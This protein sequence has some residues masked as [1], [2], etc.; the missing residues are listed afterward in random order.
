MAIPAGYAWADGPEGEC[1]RCRRTLRYVAGE[2][3][4][5]GRNHWYLETCCTG[6]GFETL[7]CGRD[8]PES[9][10]GKLL[11]LTGQWV[12]VIEA[13]GSA[14]PV[15]RAVR[16]VYGGTIAEARKLADRL[17]DGGVP[18]THGEL[19]VLQHQLATL[20]V[21]A[22]I[23]ITAPGTQDRLPDRPIPIPPHRIGHTPAEPA[24][25]VPDVIAEPERSRVGEYLR[26]AS[27]VV[28]TAGGYWVDPITRDP[29]DRIHEAVMTDGVYIWSL[30]W[31]TLVQRH[32]LSLPAE[33]LAHV[34]A[35]G[36]RPP[37]LAARQLHQA[38]VEAGLDVPDGP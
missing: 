26:D 38:T 18:G 37:E 27:C 1:V 32:G 28:A 7:A 11:E 5:D 6:C 3:F 29:R 34:R 15:M 35:L 36:Y 21:H 14:T 16:K 33:F 13:A 31:A 23:A 8:L 10:R 24:E 25:L 4:I 19:L 17:R 30:A 9:V 22:S 2:S 20:G 12:A